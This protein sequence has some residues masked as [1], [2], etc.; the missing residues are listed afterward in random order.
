VK[1]RAVRESAL[2]VIA[3]VLTTALIKI[4]S[5]GQ[6][7]AFDYDDGHRI[8]RA[9]DTSH[10]DVSYTYDDAGRLTRAMASDGTI[11]VYAYNARD[12]MIAVTEPGRA[13]ENRFDES[14]RLIKQVANLSRYAEPYVMTF[15]YI[16]DGG[17]VVQTD[18]G[19]DDGTKTIYRFNRSHYPLSET[20]DADGPSPITVAYDRNGSTNIGNTLTL[21]CRGPNGPVTRTVPLTSTF[22]HRVERVK[23]DLIREECLLHTR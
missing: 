17:S 8:V 19:E 21:S 6:S 1:P 13:V 7:I 3:V 9:H 14:G 15:A 23:E 2:G 4:E 12:E 16:L 20:S 10:H 5:A 22:E 11:R 18:I